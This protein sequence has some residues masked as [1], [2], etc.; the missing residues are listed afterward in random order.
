MFLL[1]RNELY[2]LNELTPLQDRVITIVLRQYG[3]VFNDYVSSMK[4][5]S[6]T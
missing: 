6:R 3:G 1:T 4:K 2:R 5:G